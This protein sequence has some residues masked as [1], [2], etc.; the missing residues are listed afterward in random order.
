MGFGSVIN[1]ADV[2]FWAHADGCNIG[3]DMHIV[4]MA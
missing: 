2:S 1:A 3:K 4:L